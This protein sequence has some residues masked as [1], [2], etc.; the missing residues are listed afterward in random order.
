MPRLNDEIKDKKEFKV[1]DVLYDGHHPIILISN[2]PY[3]DKYQFL[4]LVNGTIRLSTDSLLKIIKFVFE[5]N[6][7]PVD[8]DTDF[9]FLKLGN[10]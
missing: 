10:N 3:T 8:T 6:F 4:D 1:G 2:V 7:K 9:D 5:N